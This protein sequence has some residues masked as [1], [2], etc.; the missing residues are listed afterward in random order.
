[1]VGE[2]LV[3]DFDDDSNGQLLDDGASGQAATLMAFW[4][5]GVTDGDGDQGDDGMS[6]DERVFIDFTQV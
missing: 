4:E 2:G 3:E 6:R 5:E 1:V